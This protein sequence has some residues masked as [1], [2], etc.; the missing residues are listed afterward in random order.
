MGLKK[1]AI[2]SVV[3]MIILALSVAI[4]F[5]YHLIWRQIDLKNHPRE[6][7]EWVSNYSEKFGVPEYVVYAVIKTE[8]G[9]QSNKVGE[10]GAVGLMQITPARF[11]RL[12]T[13]TKATLDAGILYDPETNV[14]YGTYYLSYL[15]T[16]YNRWDM[17]FSAYASDESTVEGWRNNPEYTDGN[18]NLKEIPD[19]DVRS[20]VDRVNKAIEVYKRLYYN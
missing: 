5:A 9:F 7:S 11:S 3:I 8:S 2:R 4:G 13:M 15:Y 12:L 10:D 16:Q 1:A 6:Y 18:R 17:V 20:Y 19:E 14:E